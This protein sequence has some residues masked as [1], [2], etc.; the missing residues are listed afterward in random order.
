MNQKKEQKGAKWTL[1]L[2]RTFINKK[3]FCKCTFFSL[4]MWFYYKMIFVYLRNYTLLFSI[5][6]HVFRQPA[7][8]HVHVLQS[9][10]IES[11][12]HLWIQNNQTNWMYCLLFV[13]VYDFFY[14]IVHRMIHRYFYAYH[15]QHHKFIK[16][17]A[18]TAFYQHP[19][20]CVLSTIPMILTMYLCPISS[21]QWTV[22]SIYQKY[23]DLHEHSEDSH[24][25]L[26]HTFIYC[27]YGRYPWDYVFKTH[28]ALEQEP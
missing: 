21:L 4:K 10:V 18:I 26:H 8:L 13:V 27:N 6:R 14:Y 11:M 17:H 7:I 28:R 2:F 12:T 22:L 15:K 19:V 9:S 23:M 5:D 24:H 1:V 20:D 3:K 25:K 16:P